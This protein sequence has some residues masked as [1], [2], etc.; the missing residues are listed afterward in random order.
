M[1]LNSDSVKID[2]IREATLNREN[3]RLNIIPV[4]ERFARDALCDAGKLSDSVG[5]VDCD[6]MI[7]A[8]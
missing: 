2:F 8:Q 7:I 6:R 4:V 3:L 5:D 1:W